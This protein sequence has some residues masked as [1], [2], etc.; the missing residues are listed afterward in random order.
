MLYSLLLA[1]LAADKQHNR[2]SD[3]ENWVSI[4][5]S[6]ISSVGWG[7]QYYDY[8]KSLQIKESKF[9]LSNL[10]LEEMPKI[11]SMGKQVDTFKNIFS[12]LGTTPA[13]DSVVKAFNA[14]IYDSS[15][16]DTA[17]SFCSYDQA[18]G[19]ASLLILSLRGVKDAATT[20]PLFQT[21]TTK[22]IKTPQ[23][24]LSLLVLNETAYARVRQSVTDKLG[25]RIQ[26][27]IE[28]ITHAHM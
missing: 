9:T 15:T 10:A 5:N 28:E 21:Y 2:N 13:T 7:S 12:T 4:F 20:S 19:I 24:V 17:V 26:S 16:H 23:E 6:V 22:D 1:Q 14:K 8:I 18:G 3:T 11:G 27:Y 25:D